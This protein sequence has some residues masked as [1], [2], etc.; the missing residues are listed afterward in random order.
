[1]GMTSAWILGLHLFTWHSEPGFESATVGVYAR[2]PDGIT[3]GAYRNSEGG[4]SAYA[5]LTMETPGRQFALT[6][7]AVTGYRAA[8][9]IPLIVPSMRFSS[10]NL[11]LRVAVIP[12]I[13]RFTPATAVS[14]SIEKSF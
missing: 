13:P 10:D 14:F 9:V 12:R 4:R 7:G 5:G 11:S 2:S 3:V 8:P 1:M 6:V